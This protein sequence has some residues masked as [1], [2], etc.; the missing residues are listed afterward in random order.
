MR[1]G[2][3]RILLVCGLAMM[4]ENAVGEERDSLR[5][6]ILS[7][8]TGA[9]VR[10]VEL[11]ILKYGAKGDGVK[12]CLPAFNKAFEKV[13][14]L[15]GARINVPAGTYWLRG[16]LTLVSN[17]CI[18][19]EEGA[20]LKFDPD[21]DLYPIVSTGW[22]GTYLQNYSPMIYGRGLHDVAITGKGMIDGNAMSTF[23]TWRKH[24]KPAQ[25]RSREMNHNSVPVAER[26]FGEGDYLRP[27]L[28]QLYECERI[29]IEGVKI[30][31]SPFWC[32]H[33]LLSENI[34]CR[35]VRYDAK[36]INNDGIDPESSR[37]ILIEDVHFDNGDDNIA[38][39][40]GRDNDGWRVAR[41]SENIVI[42]NCH[43]KGLHAV[44]IGSE[45]SGGVRNVI[46][47]NCDYAGYC[48]RGIYIKT[49]PDRGGYVDGIYVHNCKF[50]DVEDLFY[51]TSQYAGEGLESR[52]YSSVGNL[53]VDGL[54]CDKASGA[55]LVLQGTSAKPIHN[56]SF[57]NVIVGEAVTGISFNDVT[58]VRI[59]ECNIG[60]R[61]G[62]PTQVS[63]KDHLFDRPK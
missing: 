52:N 44:V 60:P 8:I 35:S 24:Q 42:R 2:I 53:H 4:A 37:D 9:T 25:A 46:M 23:A 18:N 56:V 39:K 21:P 50:G 48:K 54:T 29:T 59:G 57:D 10:E 47:E 31:N 32:I 40:S 58:D 51:V 20:V 55:A 19:L 38:I 5:D 15:G 13:R 22:E 17:L 41:P 11:D 36:L 3:L 28:I 6:D 27:H 16:P 12:D 1:K 33:F 30:I 14:K 34:V 43:F 63:S 62:V 7:R 61:A 49:N 26:N 45:M